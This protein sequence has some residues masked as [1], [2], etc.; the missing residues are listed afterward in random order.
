[1]ARGE[2]IAPDEVKETAGVTTWR[3]FR[4]ISEFVDGYEFLAGLKNNVT[5][6]GSAR[7]RPEDP[8]Y[9]EAYKLGKLLAKNGYGVVTGGGPG[10]ME[11]GNKGAYEAG[12]ESLGLNI[13]LPF[14]QRINPYVRRSIGFHFFFTR[15]VMLTAPAVAFFAFPGGFGSID[16]VFEILTLIQTKKIAPTPVILVGKEYWGGI[17]SFVRNCMLKEKGTISPGDEK[18]YKVVDT[19]EEAMKEFLAW[20]RKQ[21]GKK[22]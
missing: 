14:E 9:Q 5:I 1:M 3:I 22:K 17:D 7:L 19:A 16:E 13:E 4:I 15:K 11:A 18:L 20:Q 12:G 6:F 21:K 10:I 8:S 2:V